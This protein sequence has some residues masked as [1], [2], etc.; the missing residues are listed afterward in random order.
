[1]AIDDVLAA[2]RET[3]MEIDQ[4]EVDL[5]IVKLTDLVYRSHPKA[6]SRCMNVQG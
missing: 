5:S 6:L 4:G 3:A 1:L 2:E